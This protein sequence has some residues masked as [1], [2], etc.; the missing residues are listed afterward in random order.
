MRCRG[1]RGCPGLGGGVRGPVPTQGFHG[2]RNQRLP[3]PQPGAQTGGPVR[4]QGSSDQGICGTRHAV[5]LARDGGDAGRSAAAASAERSARRAGT[6]PR[7]AQ[8]VFV[9]FARRLPRNG[10]RS[11]GLRRQRRG[12]RAMTRKHDP[13]WVWM[14]GALGGALALAGAVLAGYGTGPDGIGQAVRV[15]ARWSFLFFWLSYVGGAMAILFGPAF[16]GLA[17]RARALGLAFATALQVHIGLV[18]WLGVVIGQIP[19]QGRILLFFLA[20]LFCTYVLVLLSFGIGARKLG[21]LWRPLLFLAT[22]YILVAFG[23]DFL[24]DA[25]GQLTQ[26]WLLFVEYVPFA[27]LSLI[28]IP[29]RLAAFLRQRFEI[30]PVSTKPARRTLTHS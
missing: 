6:T 22:T 10:R 4:G 19:L 18:V 29:L 9:A 30:L 8:L 5:S 12:G 20:G 16:A 28:A 17:R 1:R 26:H 15:T 2:E 13:A 27:L 21:R 11:R 25:P 23:R 7:L 24:L 3:R 14:I